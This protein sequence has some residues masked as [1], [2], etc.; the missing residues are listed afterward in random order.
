MDPQGN[1]IDL[2]I[3]LVASLGLTSELTHFRSPNRSLA[4]NATK[5]ELQSQFRVLGLGF[6][7]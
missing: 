2:Q 3:S 7:V 5:V 1:S 4:E 6:R